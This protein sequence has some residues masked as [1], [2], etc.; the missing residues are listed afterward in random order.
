MKGTLTWHHSHQLKDLGALLPA[1]MQA[2]S[3][4]TSR[5]KP[6]SKGWGRNADTEYEQVQ[7]K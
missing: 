2:G 1:V 4:T 6:T 7:V 5:F 3:A